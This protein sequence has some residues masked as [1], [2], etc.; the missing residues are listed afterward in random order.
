MPDRDQRWPVQVD[1]EYF[2]EHLHHRCVGLVE[3]GVVY[4]ARFEEEIAWAVNHGLIRQDISHVTRG[5]LTNAGALVIVLAYVSARGKCQLSDAKLV[6]SVDFLEESFKRRLELD[7]CDQS[8]CVDL[9]RADADLRA[10][11]AR[12]CKQGHER[13]SAETPENVASDR[14][15]IWH[16]G[17]PLLIFDAPVAIDT[18][19]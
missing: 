19:K 12:L 11:F 14:P 18:A 2:E 8:L 1:R 3:D 13:R 10:C 4:V 16:D 17:P 9:D 5:H 7:F 15:I 6:L